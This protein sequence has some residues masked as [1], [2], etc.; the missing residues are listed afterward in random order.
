[1]Y[2]RSCTYGSI[3]GVTYVPTISPHNFPLRPLC[4]PQLPK[5]RLRRNNIACQRISIRLLYR[6]AEE[7]ENKTQQHTESARV[8]RQTQSKIPHTTPRLRF[9]TL[10][11][12]QHDRGTVPSKVWEAV[13]DSDRI[14]NL[15]PIQSASQPRNKRSQNSP[16]GQN[17]KDKLF[18]NKLLKDKGSHSYDWRIALSDLLEHYTPEEIDEPKDID[19]SNHAPSL[20]QTASFHAQ[21]LGSSNEFR[22]A[23]RGVPSRS[24]NYRSFRLARNITPSTEWSEAT[25]A[26]YVEALAES[27][28]T[29]ARVTWAEKPRVKGW[30]NIGDVVAAFE[31]AFYSTALQKSLSVKACNTALR[32]FYDYGMIRRARS[33]YIRMEDLKMHITTETFNILLRGSASEKDLHNFTFLLKIMIRRGFKPNEKTWTLFLQVV[34]SSEV[35]AAIVRKMTKMHMLDRIKIRRDVAALMVPYEIV[36]HLGDGH[37][38]HSFLDHMNRKYGIG[39]LSTS[40]G[41]S[42]LN[43]VAKQKS[44]AESLTLLYEM[45]KQAGFI[46][47]D[48]SMN[49]LLRHCLPLGQHELAIEI[50]DVF[51][52]LYRMHPGP[53]AYETLL[54]LS[55][56]SRLLNFFTVVWRSACVYGAISRKSHHL[57]FQSLLSYASSLD[58]HIQSDD[59]SE[60][61]D[62]I[63][64]DGIR[65]ARLNHAMDD[66]GLDP[67]QKA[68]K[69]AQRLLEGSLRLSRTCRLEHGLPQM[70][71]EALTM[72]RTWAA[73][74]LYRKDNWQ[75]MFPHAITVN[76]IVTR[77]I[78]LR[79]YASS[80]RMFR[81][82]KFASISRPF[83]PS[84]THARR[85]SLRKLTRRKL[86]IILRSNSLRKAFRAVRSR[87]RTPV[88]FHLSSGLSAVRQRPSTQ[89][90]PRSR[91][92]LRILRT[93][94]RLPI[95]RYPS[96]LPIL[97]ILRTPSRPPIKRTRVR[98]RIRVRKIKI[99][100]SFRVRKLFFSRSTA[101]KNLP[102]GQDRSTHR[103]LTQK[104]S[105]YES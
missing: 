90:S 86:G 92:R 25:L 44:T 23:V 11:Q 14:A 91:S 26:V 30:T 75:E 34:E 73:E 89:P 102:L 16:S 79:K 27:Q 51:R 56:R 53:K 64:V 78:R 22:N 83:H 47:D 94:S 52:H 77:R 19:V 32:F 8:I 67:R 84:P 85:V 46:S 13:R 88:R 37:D 68:F 39:W 24:C 9:V 33:L 5:G 103:L 7:K 104:G 1:M 3:S 35:R 54:L 18:V 62:V 71:R 41:N 105:H 57:I 12:A 70:L 93:R 43:E 20:V 81:L 38:H 60:P 97:R 96:D 6:E 72:D 31:T 48:F 36:N 87:R 21:D 50:V 99:A 40:A 63:G 2:S 69:W 42:L 4:A 28:R 82:Q 98:K 74:G 100:S 59:T 76:L 55:W 10:D 101:C 17:K 15:L 49:T 66:S 80:S 61:S 58:K 29:Q 65:G 45:K 95:L